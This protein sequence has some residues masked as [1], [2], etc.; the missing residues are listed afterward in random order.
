MICW[1]LQCQLQLFS[2]YLTYLANDGKG[3]TFQI[4][5]E[6]KFYFKKCGTQILL[7]NSGFSVLVSAVVVILLCFVIM[8]TIFVVFYA[9]P[10]SV[11]I[12]ITIIEKYLKHFGVEI[13]IVSPWERYNHQGH[14]YVED[15]NG[16]TLPP[17]ILEKYG[18]VF[19]RKTV[20]HF[21]WSELK[22]VSYSSWVSKQMR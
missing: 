4:L 6:V 15:E 18:P 10:S 7:V 21:F 2:Y 16:T 22:R 5:A 1:G 14:I 8:D 20:A 19:V 13:D 17:H 12:A 11:T 3:P 9:I